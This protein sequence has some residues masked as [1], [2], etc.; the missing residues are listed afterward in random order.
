MKSDDQLRNEALKNLSKHPEI[1]SFFKTSLET[2]IE[3]GIVSG[4]HW[5]ENPLVL[6]VLD[7]DFLER[8]ALHTLIDCISV[9][10]ENW[11]T[12][13][14]KLNP[15][16]QYDFKI[17]DVLAELHGYYFL[18]E[19]SFTDIVALPEG[20]GKTPDFTARLDEQPYLFEVKNLRAPSEIC[21]FLLVKSEARRH[22]F[23]EVYNTTSIHFKHSEGWLSVELHPED[24]TS[25][26]LAVEKWLQQAFIR[27]ESCRIPAS[28]CVDTFHS[29]DDSLRIECDIKIANASGACCGLTSWIC[30][31]DPK[32]T[33]SIVQPF[34]G[35]VQR[36]AE[37][38]I[39]Q[40]LV[41]D[42]DN[43]YRKYVLLNW[44]KSSKCASLAWHGFDTDVARVIGGV[45]DRLKKSHEGV[46][47]ELLQSDS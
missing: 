37:T 8:S 10:E 44:Q 35:K 47:V 46:T 13:K 28:V 6:A 1:E 5:M 19:R 20:K 2:R 39:G 3:L 7:A 15:R 32:Y 12:L 36:V 23:P 14:N 26:V 40:L 38:A 42:K 21:H 16:D 43:T 17:R 18:R 29:A 25:L 34:A 30:V 33:D 31:S 9:D 27:I 22:R 24:R 41:Y 45:T 4:Y 11:N